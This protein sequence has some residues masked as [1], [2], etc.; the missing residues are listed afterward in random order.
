MPQ[1]AL[2]H[3]SLRDNLGSFMF[4][5][6]SRL[7]TQRWSLNEPKGIIPDT[8]QSVP[9]RTRH[10]APESGGGDLPPDPLALQAPTQHQQELNSF[11]HTS[12]MFLTT[13][14]YSSIEPFITLHLNIAGASL[15]RFPGKLLHMI[16]TF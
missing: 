2:Q 6:V 8:K 5:Y 12:G 16:Q 7:S 1:E 11:Q 9:V 3:H 4:H 15:P 10:L 14:P 13:K